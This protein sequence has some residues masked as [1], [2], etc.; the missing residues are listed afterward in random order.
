MK[1]FEFKNTRCTSQNGEVRFSVY[2]KQEGKFNSPNIDII[3]LEELLGI[4]LKNLD[5][6]K[7]TLTNK[8]S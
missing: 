8:G 2:N 3:K 4:E 7:L 6:F 5:F 1:Q